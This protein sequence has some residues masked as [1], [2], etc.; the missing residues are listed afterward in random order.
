MRTKNYGLTEFGT[1]IQIAKWLESGTYRSLV[2][3][4][5]G[6]YVACDESEKLM[7]RADTIPLLAD[8]LMN[9][10]QDAEKLPESR[11]IKV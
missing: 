6:T 7:M 2:H 11:W 5:D 1:H 3:R 10:P 9:Y 8:A 4:H